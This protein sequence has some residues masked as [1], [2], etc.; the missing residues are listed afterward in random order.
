MN[1]GIKKKVKTLIVLAFLLILLPELVYVTFR[2]NTIQ[3][4]A[5]RWLMDQV[6]QTF[7]T[8]IKV[9]GIDISFFDQIT[10]EK[11]L[12][13]DQSHDTLLYVDQLR[14]QIDSLKPGSRHVHLNSIFVQQP[15]IYLYQDTAGTNFQFIL[16]SIKASPTP[17]ED[18]KAW[19]IRFKNLFVRNAEIRFRKPFA[20][21]I[22][23]EGIN[24]NDLYIRKMNFALVHVKKEESSVSML[25]DNAALEEKSGFSIKNLTFKALLDSSGLYLDKFALIT[26]NSNIFFRFT[27]DYSQENHPAG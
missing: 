3:T 18:S 10:L 27:A 1:K 16:D 21:T 23:H 15:K 4:F 19:D 13:E 24:F 11:I 26:P 7:N 6:G 12:I 20:D 25:L 2:S 22:Y 14:L 8:K 9:G 5:V 17:A